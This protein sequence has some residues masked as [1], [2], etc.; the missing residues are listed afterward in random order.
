MVSAL[1]PDEDDPRRWRGDTP[2]LNITDDRLRLRVKTVLQFSRTEPERLRAICNYVAAI[3]FNVPA[4]TPMK[5]TRRTLAR[6]HAVGW[7]SKAALFQAMLRA[8]GFAARVRMIRIGPDMHRGLTDGQGSFVLPVV[9]VWTGGRW[10]VT[11][12]YVYD[13]IYLA[14]AREAVMRRGWRS[15]YGVHLDGQTDWN[16]VDDALIMIVPD[17]SAGPVPRQYLGVYDDPLSYQ[18]QIRATAWWRWLWL[19]TRNRI[20]SI[21]MNRQVRRLRS[22]AGG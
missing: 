13:P 1:P 18:Q 4:F 15:G 17:R 22:E 21:R 19:L 3:P 8:A 2:M 10:V 16:G 7:Y 20:T 12:N 5:S 11:D 9:E 14:V 6:R